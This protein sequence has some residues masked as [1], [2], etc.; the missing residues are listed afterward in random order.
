MLHRFPDDGEFGLKIQHA[1]LDY[2]ASSKAAQ[3]A[4]AENYIGLPFS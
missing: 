3:T 1:E 2:L 4:L